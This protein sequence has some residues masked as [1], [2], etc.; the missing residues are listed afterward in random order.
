M[1]HEHMPSIRIIAIQSPYT[2]FGAHWHPAVN[3]YETDTA[4]VVIAEMAGVNLASLH[5]EVQPRLLRVTGT[6]AIPTP[7]EVRRLHRM[8]I[9][10]GPFHIDVP[11][12]VLIDAERAESRY[13]DG[14]LEIILPFAPRQSQRVAIQITDGGRS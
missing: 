7:G 14:L 2:S 11:L 9:A 10:S 8:D 12:N 6:R 4:L 5:V 1:A 13:S 3:I